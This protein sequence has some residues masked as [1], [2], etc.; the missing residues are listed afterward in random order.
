MMGTGLH[1]VT[2]RR[3]GKPTLYYVYAWRGGPQISQSEGTKPKI[4]IALNDLAA[5]ERRKLKLPAEDSSLNA[6]ITLFKSSPEFTKTADSTQAN[7]RTWLDRIAEEFGD[8]T[9]RMWHSREMRGD[10]LDWRDRWQCQPRSAD[11]AVKV[12]AR[13]VNW[14]L[15]RGRL[16]TNVLTGIDHL[17][18]SDRS[19][20]I[21]EPQHF[22]LVRP[23]ASVEVQEGIDLAACTGLRRGDLVRLPWSAVGEH[24]IIWKTSKSK[25]RTQIAVPML[26]ETHELLARIKARYED[27]MAKQ[28]PHRRKPLPETVLSNSRWEPWQ[29]GGFGS[30]FNDAKV[31]SKLDRNLHDLRGTF[32]TRVCMVGLTDDEIA[33]IVGWDTKDIA[34]IREKYVNNARVVIAIGERIAKA[35]TA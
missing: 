2:K 16:P 35:T 30:R 23:H 10:V 33:K 25:G 1:I 19:D 11:E 31:A 8:T 7:Y 9:L 6:Q 4:T 17:Y 29:P 27:A 24:A 3:R 28:R 21:W 26:P 20:L 18:D 34:A 22:A 14:I 15:D 13:L 32:I 12:F 5:E